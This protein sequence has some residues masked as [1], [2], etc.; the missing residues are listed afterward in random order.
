M[1]SSGSAAARNTSECGMV[2]S[3][4]LIGTRVCSALS[5]VSMSARIDPPRST[6]RA[7]PSTSK[8]RCSARS[9]S[10]TRR[11]PARASGS[12]PVSTA[13]SHSVPIPIERCEKLADP[14]RASTSSTI[15]TF[16]WTNV[17]TSR[18]REAIGYMSRRRL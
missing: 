14:I 18:D 11:T 5:R 4:I 3:E 9:L 1:G 6:P 17:G 16:E 15:I 10:R 7:I 12:P 13:R 2:F 8:P